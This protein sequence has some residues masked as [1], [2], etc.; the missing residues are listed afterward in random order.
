MQIYNYLFF[1]SKL[2]NLIK[3]LLIPPKLNKHPPWDGYPLPPP[4]NL[5]H[6][7]FPLLRTFYNCLSPPITY[8]REVDTMLLEILNELCYASFIKHYQL[9]PKKIDDS[10]TID[11][12]DEIV[13]MNHLIANHHV[14]PHLIK[15]SMGE[16]LRCLRAEFIIKLSF[17]F[18]N[19]IHNHMK[20]NIKTKCTWHNYEKI[21]IV[22]LLK[23][24]PIIELFSK[25]CFSVY[26]GSKFCK[27]CKFP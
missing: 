14:Y 9:P 24:H 5:F 16:K 20:E 3:L 8:G 4:Q 13:E 26:C 23:K 11:L 1:P 18:Y 12:T 7:T 22:E 19:L 2:E 21:H 10:Q 15:L 6:T 25:L 27:L 17:A